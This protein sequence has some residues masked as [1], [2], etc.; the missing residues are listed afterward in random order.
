MVVVEL[1]LLLFPT[2]SENAPLAT[3]TEPEPL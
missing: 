3:E 2:A 1:A